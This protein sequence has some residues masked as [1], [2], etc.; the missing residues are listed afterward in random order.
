MKQ[1]NSQ[2]A[3]LEQTIRDLINAHVASDGITIGEL[4][5]A[6]EAIKAEIL[7]D[8]YMEKYREDGNEDD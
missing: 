7:F 8:Y 2:M 3:E 1:P 5:G 6:L 4:T